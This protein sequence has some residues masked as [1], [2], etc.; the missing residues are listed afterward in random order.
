MKL[1]WFKVGAAG[2]SI[3]LAVGVSLV[4][5]IAQ[6]DPSPCGSD[7]LVG[8]VNGLPRCEFSRGPA[9]AGNSTTGWFSVPDF[10]SSVTVEAY[11]GAG[12]SVN[13]G[14]VGG[15]GAEVT[16]TLTVS[17][18][19]MLDFG[20]EGIGGMAG[21]AGYCNNGSPYTNSWDGA[22]GGYTKISLR[23]DP[24]TLLVA[25]GGGGA[26]CGDGVNGANG[27]DAGLPGYTSE[28]ISYDPVDATAGANFDVSTGGGGAT[29]SAG[30]TGG[31]GDFCSGEDGGSYTAGGDTC[32]SG[33]PG[34]GGGG[35]YF[36]GGGGGSRG[37][38]GGGGSSYVSG[39][40]VTTGA[41]LHS[42]TF[43]SGKINIFYVVNAPVPNTP[44]D[45]YATAGNGSA[46]VEID[47]NWDDPQ[48]TSFTVTS[49]PD[50]LTC[51]IDASDWPLSCRVYDLTNGTPYT[52]RVVANNDNGSSPA[53]DPSN[54]VTPLPDQTLRPNIAIDGVPRTGQT[55]HANEGTWD[56]GAVLYYQWYD[57][58]A[59]VSGATNANFTLTN[60]MLGHYIWLRITGK[61][62]GH[63]DYTTYANPVL[64][65]SDKPSVSGTMRVGET[66][67]CDEGFWPSGTT[68]S[69]QWYA[70]NV[71]ISGATSSSYTLSPSEV[72]KKMTV[73]ITGTRS[74]SS[75][76]K[77]AVASSA[78]APGLLVNT[79][80]PTVSGNYV[81]GQTLTA[82]P[83]SWDSGVSFAYS[84]F[85]DGLAI[86]GANTSSYTIAMADGGKA[87]AV[88]VTATKVGYQ[89]ERRRN[90]YVSV[91]AYIRQT[92]TDTP[93]LTGTA[94]NGR[95]L[96]FDPGSNWD[97][98][99]TQHWVWLRNGA[100][101]NGIDD[102]TSYRLRSVD[103]GKRIAVRLIS[104][105]P[106][107]FNEIRT[108]SSSLVAKAKFLEADAPYL[109]GTARVGEVI[110]VDPG[111]W[112]DNAILSYQWYC[113]STPIDGATDSSYRINRFCA[114]TKISVKIT[115]SADGYIPMTRFS[116][117]ISVPRN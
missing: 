79:P 10:V 77:T 100:L 71:A 64:V 22:G 23:S 88:V 28:G 29:T 55:L 61:E 112:D 114:G 62:D 4:P 16:A 81:I 48:P 38:G 95:N 116:S 34:G 82:D 57:N 2:L 80:F 107:R 24:S 86:P 40:F 98:D 72:R 35:G 67:S 66:I 8:Y 115:G 70:N 51:T 49:D 99:S 84:W 5:Q 105:E 90:A 87:L 18:G 109:Y 78:V 27:G 117:K 111:F 42:E 85:R 9:R 13:A 15:R 3:A 20:A 83:G 91:P 58:W 93:S 101:I 108:V 47:P 92:L 89:T 30:G 60:S 113:N 39:S 45:L 65:K 21:A 102:A 33:R 59:P 110:A 73:K 74:G 1:S 50:G 44:Y 68:F 19:D 103:V 36:G 17:P 97:A 12:T 41:Y 26:G 43:M 104:T 14:A 69:Y 76:I 6:A 96:Y 46:L 106:S 63:W 52:F 31:T 56:S 25:A 11:G 37:G 94:T 75:G 53:S 54:E 7:T 32:R